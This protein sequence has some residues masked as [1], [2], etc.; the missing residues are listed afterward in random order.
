[1]QLSVEIEY[2]V[3]CHQHAWCS[4][5]DEDKYRYFYEQTRDAILKKIKV[6]DDIAIRPKDVPT[7]FQKINKHSKDNK[8]YDIQKDQEVYFPRLGSFEVFVDGVLVFSK[9]KSS[10]WPNTEK[11][12]ETVIMMLIAKR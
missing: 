5:H 11:L 9:L 12:S 4:Q 3:N 10:L 7:H 1:M 2:C 8:Y 6:G